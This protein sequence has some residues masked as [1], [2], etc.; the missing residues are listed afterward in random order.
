[1]KE[2]V[3]KLDMF[4]RFS[5]FDIPDWTTEVIYNFVTGVIEDVVK[6]VERTKNG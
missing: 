3:R 4:A 2:L 1:M 5:G 6:T